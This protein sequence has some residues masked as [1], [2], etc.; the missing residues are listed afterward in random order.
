MSY[1]RDDV[2]TIVA[3][4]NPGAIRPLGGATWNGQSGVVT[5][6]RSGRFARFSTMAWGL[7]ALLRNLDTYIDRHGLNT[8]R[9][10]INRWA[11]PVEN[12]TS[13]YAIAVANAL[14]VA[15]DAPLPRDYPTMRALMLA[16]IRHE[17]GG[18]VPAEADIAEAFRIMAVEEE[19]RA[20]G[21]PAPYISGRLGDAARR[22]PRRKPMEVGGA[23]GAAGGGVLVTLWSYWS[24]V[25]L[26]LDDLRNLFPAFEMPP[27]RTLAMIA[28]AALIG[29]VVWRILGNGDDDERRET[30]G[31]Q[32]GQST[33]KPGEWE[34]DSREPGRDAALARPERHGDAEPAGRLD[35]DDH[36]EWSP[37]WE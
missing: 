29:W 6:G 23:A 9:Q 4:N 35:A 24:Q 30:G 25:T 18:F 16:I 15:P 33:D 12:D 27:P 1:S 32:T 36:A 5:A 7:R 34:P 8:V 14:G 2:L 21:D 13:A 10:I 3:A 22:L 31:E 17:T 37:R 20:G 19:R 28:A 26:M 11:P